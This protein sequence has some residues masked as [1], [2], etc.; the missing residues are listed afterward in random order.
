MF[1]DESSTHTSL[2]RLYGWAPHDQRATGVVPRN[3]G[4]NLTLVAALTWEGMQASWAIEGAMDTAAFEVYVLRV[5]VPTLRPGQV[6]IMDNLSV[7]KA[8][9]IEDAI[10]AC[11][12]TLRFLPVYSPD[13]NPIE[14]AFSKLKAFLR[15]LG[16]RTRETL[17][18]A[19]AIALAHI[20]DADASAW[21][22]HAGYS[23]PAL[24]P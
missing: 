22:Q 4:K 2:T 20:T 5:L 21:F 9:R 10:I 18:D 14:H 19:L 12:C 24:S 11:G 7:H 17:L 1:V 6:V 8:A 3:H 23:M 15:K 16:S 13:F